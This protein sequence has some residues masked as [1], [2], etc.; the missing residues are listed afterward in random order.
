MGLW[1]VYLSTQQA[2]PDG[3]MSEQQQEEDGVG[4]P[5]TSAAALGWEEEE[6]VSSPMDIEEAVVSGSDRPYT[7]HVRLVIDAHGHDHHPDE[8][9]MPVWMAGIHALRLD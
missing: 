9:D 6:D 1:L 2:S 5:A 8:T 4:M 7:G 3:G